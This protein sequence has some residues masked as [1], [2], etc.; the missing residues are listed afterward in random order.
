MKLTFDSYEQINHFMHCEDDVPSDLVEL[1]Y[2][3]EQAAWQEVDRLREENERLRKAMDNPRLH[4]LCELDNERIK[5][6]R[7]I[8]ERE[9]LKSQLDDAVGRM[10]IIQ[11][12]IQNAWDNGQFYDTG[13]NVD[14]VID[15]LELAIQRIKGEGTS[16]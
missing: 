5:K 4:L 3:S 14:S 11:L 12:E 16:E 6:D 15:S 8:T 1:L 13:F 9:R 2:E 10:S 7:A